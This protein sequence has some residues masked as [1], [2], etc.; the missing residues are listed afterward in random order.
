MKNL[1]ENCINVTTLEE[2]KTLVSE[3]NTLYTSGE[4]VILDLEEVKKPVQ[5]I[6]QAY[7]NAFIFD[8]IETA[9]TSK[10]T[11]IQ[12]LL[13]RFNYKQIS[14]KK[15]EN[16][17]LCVVEADAKNNELVKLFDF[18]KLERAFQVAHST[19]KDKNGNPI[20]NKQETIFAQLRIYGLTAIFTQN[21]LANI[22]FENAFVESLKLEKITDENGKIFDENDN[23]AF[24]SNSNNDLEKQLNIIVRLMGFDG[25]K[26]FG[27]DVKIIRQLILKI[28]QNKQN[29]KHDI[30]L[31]SEFVIWNNIFSRVVE[32]YEQQQAKK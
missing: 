26:L 20:P 22:K 27:T 7:E 19:D 32:R 17:T 13:T 14:V 1:N 12:S 18:A 24:K 10:K 2:L 11:A 3:Y 16:G 28:K 6:N 31:V 15:A 30:K 25:V 23:K 4:S 21:L 9:K 5:K 29:A 8:F